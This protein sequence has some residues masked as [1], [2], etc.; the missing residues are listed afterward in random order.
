MISSYVALSRLPSNRHFLS[1]VIFGSAV[2]IASGRSVTFHERNL[3]PKIGLEPFL[4]PQG[5]GVVVR[6]HLSQDPGSPFAASA[7]SSMSPTCGWGVLVRPDRS[8]LL[9]YT[10]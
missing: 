4:T 1:D 5:T 6:L 9:C 3:Q 10:R 7:T 2:G 8:A